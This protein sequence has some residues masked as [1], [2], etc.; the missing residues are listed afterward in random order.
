MNINSSAKRILAFGDSTTWGRIPGNDNNARY[1]ADKRWTGILQEILGDS[2]EVIEEGLNGR[3]TNTESPQ[4]KGKNGKEYLF[5][6]LESQKPL[7][8]VIL[9]LGKNDLKS[10]Y[11]RLPKDISNGLEECINVFQAEGRTLTGKVPKLIIVSPVIVEEQERERFGKLEVDF[12][13]ANKKSK[14]LTLLYKRLAEKYNAYFLDIS[15]KL[16]VSKI[17]GVHLDEVENEKL[18]HL[19]YEAIKDIE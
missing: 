18:G 17:D 9:F 7:D 4:K 3:T 1:S 8:I 15:T 14:E 19:L 5:A 2:Y 13:G 6:C 16:I 12:L 10:K 11:K